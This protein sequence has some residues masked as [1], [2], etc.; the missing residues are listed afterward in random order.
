MAKK[1]TRAYD[2]EIVEV[3]YGINTKLNKVESVSRKRNGS[4][5]RTNADG[6]MTPHH[7]MPG[8]NA[9]TEV[10][11]AFGLSD[12]FSFPPSMWDAE[13]VKKKIEE[14]EAKLT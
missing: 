12:V 2:D 3:F 8:K 10:V 7:P 1:G 14:L 13:W 11:I 9:L 5:T 4:L 6:T